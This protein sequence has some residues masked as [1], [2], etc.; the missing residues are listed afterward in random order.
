[1]T[2]ENLG[3]ALWI[4]GDKPQA[5]QCFRGALAYFRSVNAP[6]YVETLEAAMRRRG[7]EP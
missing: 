7:L 2:T 5:E 6:Y 1:M 4:K 3:Y